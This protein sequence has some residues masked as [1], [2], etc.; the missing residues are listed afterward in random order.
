MRDEFIFLPFY[1]GTDIILVHHAATQ[2]CQ[3]NISVATSDSQ[4]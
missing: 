3:I 4:T 1:Y 2:L